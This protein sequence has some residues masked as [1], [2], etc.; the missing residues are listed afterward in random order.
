MRN[1]A[2]EFPHDLL[3][4]LRLRILGNKEILAKSQNCTGTELHVQSPLAKNKFLA[5][6]LKR[7]AQRI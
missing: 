5:L 7:Y 4:V 1:L 2:Y 3:N 6:A